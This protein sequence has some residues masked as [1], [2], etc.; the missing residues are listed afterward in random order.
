MNLPFFALSYRAIT[1]TLLGHVTISFD[2]CCWVHSKSCEDWKVR[3]FLNS[4]DYKAE[5]QHNQNCS[6]YTEKIEKTFIL[7]ENTSAAMCCKQLY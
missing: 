6:K 2:C 1:I 7:L 4:N 5:N 3:M